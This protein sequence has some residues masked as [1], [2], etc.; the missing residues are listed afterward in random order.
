SIRFSAMMHSLSARWRAAFDRG[1][2]VQSRRISMSKL[3]PLFALALVACT[4]T[5]M[6]DA[7]PLPQDA[8][9][10]ADRGERAC[11]C[12]E[13]AEWGTRAC[14]GGGWVDE[15]T[16]GAQD[17]GVSLDSDVPAIDAGRDAGE[18]DGGSVDAGGGVDAGPAW[19]EC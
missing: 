13:I 9:F 2:A 14:V 11:W 18:V 6:P 1:Y 19:G 4:D 17:A 10:C 8:G 16:C 3:A 15:C 12:E 7:G 5:R